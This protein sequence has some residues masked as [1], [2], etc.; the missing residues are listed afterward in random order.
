M[1]GWIESDSATNDVA[2]ATHAAETNKSHVIAGVY[3]S[4]ST[5]ASALLE[6]K[7]GSTVLFSAQIYDS[8]HITFPEGIAADGLT[9]IDDNIAVS[10]VLA[11]GGGVVVGY[12]NLFG[13]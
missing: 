8:A 10:A 4:F 5:T 6:V 13:F 3:A 11:A 9:S 2:T 1:A 7:R 12:V